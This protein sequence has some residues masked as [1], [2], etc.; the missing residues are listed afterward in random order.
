[1]FQYELI[2]K[3]DELFEKYLNIRRNTYTE[4]R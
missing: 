3:A 2:K 1:M 4:M